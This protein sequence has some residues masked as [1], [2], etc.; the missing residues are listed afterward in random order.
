VKVLLV[1]V[2]RLV[3]VEKLIGVAVTSGVL[4]EVEEEFRVVP[5]L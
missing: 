2:E 4:V 1:L 3:E 5:I